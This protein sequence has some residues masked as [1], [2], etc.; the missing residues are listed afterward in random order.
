MNLI[1]QPEGSNLCGQSCVAMV[2]GVSL[3]QSIATF[4][5]RGKTKTR[6]LVRALAALKV[7]CGNHLTRISKNIHPPASCIMNMRWK[8]SQGR[9]HGHWIV[10]HQGKYYD[11]AYG[12]ICSEYPREWGRLTSYLEIS[13]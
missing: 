11:P 9:S 6:D 10:R 7:Q 1:M 8:D 3:K 4:G 13:K 12:I 2:A 5:K